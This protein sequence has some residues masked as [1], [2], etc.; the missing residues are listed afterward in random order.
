M[1]GGRVM[2][3]AERLVLDA[4]LDEI[5]ERGTL[6]EA[7]IPLAEKML[8]SKRAEIERLREL[9]ETGREIINPAPATLVS[10]WLEHVNAALAGKEE[11]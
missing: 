1:S 10:L 8:E 7:V 6:S 4:L 11:N 9:L 3:T 5:Y 2:N